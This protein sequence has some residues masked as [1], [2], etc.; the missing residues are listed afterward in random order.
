MGTDKKSVNQSQTT[1]RQYRGTWDCMRST[2]K[3]EGIR[4]VYAGF[5]ISLFG[6]VIFRGLFLGGYDAVK[7]SFDIE[8][9]SVGVRLVAAQVATFFICLSDCFEGITRL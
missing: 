6:V 1:N 9:S 3:L 2:Y 4:G 5:V 7:Y 8:K